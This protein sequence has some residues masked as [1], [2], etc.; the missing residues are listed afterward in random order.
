MEK[1]L[2]QAG[3]DVLYDDR[4][5][6]A[7]VK[8]NDADLIGIPMQVILGERNLAEGAVEVKLRSEGSIQKMP[9]E[10]AAA[11]LQQRKSRLRPALMVLAACFFLFRLQPCAQA[12]TAWDKGG[13]GVANL[14][15]FPYEIVRQGAIDFNSPRGGIGIFTGGFRGVFYGVVRAL[16]GAYD[17]VTFPIP[18]PAGY[19]PLMQPEFIVPPADRG[20]PDWGENRI[21]RVY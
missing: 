19:R 14:V 12:Y 11:F 21:E 6:R 9:L 8:F 3:L 13:R 2:T 7:G 1:T 16:A 5:E 4:D 20:N 18:L 10:R 15:T 17:L